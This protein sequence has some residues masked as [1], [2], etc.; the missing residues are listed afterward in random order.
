MME[1]ASTSETSV[2]FY[3]VTRRNI[4]EDSRLHTCRRENLKSHRQRY[5]IPPK[6]KMFVS[7]IFARIPVLQIITKTI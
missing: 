6:W 4:P 5:I 2:Y 7:K 3:Q 1:A